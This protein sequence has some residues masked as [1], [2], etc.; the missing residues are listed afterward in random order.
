MY[1]CLSSYI[2]SSR[3]KETLAQYAQAL[4]S[5]LQKLVAEHAA[6]PVAYRR[7]LVIEQGARV[8]Q[9]V[10]VAAVLPLCGVLGLHDNSLFHGAS[11]HLWSGARKGKGNIDG[12]RRHLR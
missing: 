3:L 10:E 5:G 7:A 6:N 11:R 1:K 4:P 2:Y 8:A 9:V 12:A